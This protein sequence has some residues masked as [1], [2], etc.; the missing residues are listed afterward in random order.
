MKKRT[1]YSAGKKGEAET[2]PA[3]HFPHHLQLR[4]QVPAFVKQIWNILTLVNNYSKP[5]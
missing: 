1:Q 4:I 5:Y 3:E 2:H